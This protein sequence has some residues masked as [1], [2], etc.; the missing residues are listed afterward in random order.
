MKRFFLIF[1]LFLFLASPVSAV[2]ATAIG[3]LTLESGSI[4]IR[5]SGKDQIIRTVGQKIKIFNGDELQT[6]SKSQAT[7]LLLIKKD[8][9]NLYSNSFLNIDKV[10][11]D[12][13]DIRLPIGK[14]KFKVRPLG[15]ALRP[16]QRR[17]FQVR[18][19]NALVGVKGTEFVLATGAEQTNLLTLDGAVALSNLATPEVEVEVGQ[20]QASQITKS[21]A[22]TQPVQVSPQSVQSI[23]TSESPKA[24]GAVKFGAPVV[25]AGDKKKGEKQPAKKKDG[26][27]SDKKSVDKKQTNQNAA[28]GD[29]PPKKGAV[30]GPSTGTG[31]VGGPDKAAGGLDKGPGPDG[32]AQLDDPEDKEGGPG[33]EGEGPEA[34]PGEP[35][36][37]GD[38][39]G[40]DDAGPQPTGGPELEPGGDNGSFL[41]IDEAPSG[42]D[43][44]DFS[45]DEG[46]A[47]FEDPAID[48]I[49]LDDVLIDIP[50]DDIVDQVG[51]VEDIITD[52]V[53]TPGQTPV[54]IQVNH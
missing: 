36:A 43:N 5:R 3:Q 8:I 14:A 29:A 10:A 49:L 40:A 47:D 2:A 44:A 30:G 46:F 24:W 35:L 37:E 53:D 19:V 33:I 9:I 1:W 17:P 21:A 15:R 38:D 26:P 50:I 23:L 48:E 54:I 4:K 18:T 12:N 20:N 52:Q 51:V 45:S 39:L 6:G 22:P 13:R 28:K 31:P 25:E 34:K 42:F 41:V 16:G 11:G 32:G 27:K 7:L